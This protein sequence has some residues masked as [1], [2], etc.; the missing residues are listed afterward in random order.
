MTKTQKGTLGVGGFAFT[1]AISGFLYNNVIVPW[2]YREQL[3]SCL[4]QARSLED[5]EERDEAENI[6]FRTYPHFL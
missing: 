3:H 4:S 5:K 6:C 2:P 1:A